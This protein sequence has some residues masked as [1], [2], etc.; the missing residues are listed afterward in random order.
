MAIGLD[1]NET[2]EL[3]DLLELAVHAVIAEFLN[4]DIDSFHPHARLGTELGLSPAA[5]KRLRTE[6]VLIFDIPEI[7]VFDTVTVG[8][9]VDQVAQFELSRLARDTPTR[10]A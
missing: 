6:I 2:G 1:R 10:V 7:T 8:D 4:T 9:L 5:M 3:R